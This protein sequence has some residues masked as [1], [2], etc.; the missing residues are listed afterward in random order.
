MGFSF[1]D[2]AEGGDLRAEWGNMLRLCYGSRVFSG[3]LSI[4][5]QVAGLEINTYG[6]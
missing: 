5:G 4:H 1:K 2:K 6:Y 3:D